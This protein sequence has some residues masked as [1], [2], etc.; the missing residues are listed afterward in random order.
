[1]YG[2]CKSVFKVF[3]IF[4]HMLC[5]QWI[6]VLFIISNYVILI[7]FIFYFHFQVF[8]IFNILYFHI[9]TKFQSMFLTDITTAWYQGVRSA[10]FESLALRNP[11]I[12]GHKLYIFS[13]FF[14]LFIHQ[15]YVVR[16]DVNLVYCTSIHLT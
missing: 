15:F 16:I 10:G 5:S 7:F 3:N 2:P 1:M 9:E 4:I 6:F 14:Y 11:Y 8:S 13:H 12:S